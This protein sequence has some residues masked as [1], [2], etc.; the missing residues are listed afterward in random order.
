[1]ASLGS[2]SSRNTSH[3]C[4]DSSRAIAQPTTPPP[5]TTTLTRSM[6]IVLSWNDIYGRAASIGL[7]HP[8]KH[9]QEDQQGQEEKNHPSLVM[10]PAR[11]ETRVHI[12]TQQSQSGNPNPILD[13]RQGKCQESQNQFFPARTKVQMGCE[14]TGNKERHARANTAAFLSY[15]N[16]DRGQ[17]QLKT[18]AQ[19]GCP[20]SLENEI[21]NLRRALLQ[22][23]DDPIQNRIRERDHQQQKQQGK[24]S[25]PKCRLPVEAKK[26]GDPYQDYRDHL[27]RQRPIA[28]SRY[29][30]STG[31]QEENQCRRSQANPETCACR[32]IRKY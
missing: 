3:Q 30:A 15:F 12:N 22:L 31:H 24:R 13:E 6:A 4:E 25:R 11:Q 5:I 29:R 17:R 23:I 10:K 19:D 8:P 20:G 7:F 18:M 14:Q 2:A 26:A 32:R 27:H 1:M 21:C 16:R 28:F 9:R